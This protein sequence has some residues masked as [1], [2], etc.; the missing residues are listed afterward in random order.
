MTVKEEPARIL[1]IDDDPDITSTFMAGLEEKGFVV[2]IFN[3]P[4]K[5]LT[6]FTAGL[7]DLTL[8]M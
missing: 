2:T 5:A 8:S 3:D 6:K 7:Y 1:I 4:L